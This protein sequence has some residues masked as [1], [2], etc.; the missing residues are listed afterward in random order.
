MEKEE[1]RTE[2][3]KELDERYDAIDSLVRDGF[4]PYA[5]DRMSN[6]EVIALYYKVEEGGN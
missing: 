1:I 4:D 3:N 2:E 5:L 6:K